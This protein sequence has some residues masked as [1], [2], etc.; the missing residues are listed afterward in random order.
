MTSVAPARVSDPEEWTYQPLQGS[1]IR[2]ITLDESR[3]E[4]HIKCT[5]RHFDLDEDLEF[6]AL[7]YVWGNPMATKQILVNDRKFEITKNLHDALNSLSKL[8]AGQRWWWVD[9]ICIDQPNLAEKSKQIPRMRHIYPYATVVTCWLG[10]EFDG[11][12]LVA[13]I[14]SRMRKVSYGNALAYRV[15][16][17]L[18]DDFPK[19]L[20]SFGKLI[21]NEW[22]ARI[23]TVQEFALN[24]RQIGLVGKYEIS[25]ISLLTI[26]LSLDE[27]RKDLSGAE[28]AMLRRIEESERDHGGMYLLNSRISNDE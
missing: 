16:E 14:T 4:G 8:S 12:E 17:E 2:L 24:D 6:Y 15:K 18:G 22:F 27:M 1:E 21:V 28:F 5:L 26:R 23:W 7:S 11:I 9:A 19:F 20:Y 3:P 25:M 13:R 10:A